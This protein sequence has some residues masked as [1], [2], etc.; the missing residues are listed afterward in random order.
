MSF[1]VKNHCEI[2][3]MELA[4]ETAALLVERE[5][6]LDSAAVFWWREQNRR[7]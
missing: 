7:N 5:K 3:E 2:C 6:R 4:K 1:A